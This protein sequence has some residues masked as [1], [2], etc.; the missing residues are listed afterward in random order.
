MSAR[1]P[2]LINSPPLLLVKVGLP[3]LSPCPL[4]SAMLT[5]RPWLSDSVFPPVVATLRRR[6]RVETL[7]R[8]RRVRVRVEVRE[9]ALLQRETG[10]GARRVGSLEGAEKPG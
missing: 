10:S 3:A 6:G 4:A 9:R 7:S 1:A 2:A 5:P 8:V